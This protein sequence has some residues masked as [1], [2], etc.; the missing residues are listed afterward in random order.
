[1]RPWWEWNARNTALGGIY[2]R[3]M[4]LLNLMLYWISALGLL[5]V[6]R[7]SGVALM[8]MAPFAT[9]AIAY[10]VLLWRGPFDRPAA[11]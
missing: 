2:G 7:A 3:P 11:S 6:A 8:L 1:M 4:V 5:K 10:G 9:L